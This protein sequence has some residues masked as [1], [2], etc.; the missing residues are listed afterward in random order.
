MSQKKKREKFAHKVLMPL[1]MSLT[2]LLPFIICYVA[3]N[4]LTAENPGNFENS[5]CASFL[6]LT[7]FNFL[8]LK[9]RNGLLYSVLI[10]CTAS[11]MLGYCFV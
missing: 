3:Y 9:Y 2:A 7:G 4:G 5:F 8:S 6:V 1:L 10:G 11:L